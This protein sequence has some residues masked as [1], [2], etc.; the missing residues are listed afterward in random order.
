MRFPPKFFRKRRT[1][2]SRLESEENAKLLR[3]RRQE[4][5]ITL[6]DG[7]R[8]LL[9]PGDR[10]G[11]HRANLME[12]EY[13]RGDDAEIATPAAQRPEQVGVVVLAGDDEAAVGQHDVG[14]DQ[15]VDGQAVFAGEITV[16]AAQ[17]QA[18][19]AGG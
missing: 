17:G 10:S 12:L 1:G 7:A 19:D 14:L 4:L 5:A 11:K 3:R 18:G 8:M 13:K 9:V 2:Q 16:A 15:I 6:H